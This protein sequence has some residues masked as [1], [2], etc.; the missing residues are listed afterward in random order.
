MTIDGCFEDALQ[1]WPLFFDDAT[2]PAMVVIDVL[3]AEYQKKKK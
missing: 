1:Q 3:L 2:C